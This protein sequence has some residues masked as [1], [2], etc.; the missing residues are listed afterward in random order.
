[1]TSLP[2]SPHALVA[3]Q[4]DAGSAA[5]QTPGPPATSTFRVGVLTQLSG[6]LT[7]LSGVLTQ[8]SGNLSRGIYNKQTSHSLLGGR[9]ECV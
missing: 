3:E 5:R 2:T 8:L 7:Q 4:T 1:M 6:V 9:V